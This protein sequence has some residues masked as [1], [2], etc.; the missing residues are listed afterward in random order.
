MTLR[1]LTACPSTCDLIYRVGVAAEITPGFASLLDKQ[2]AISGFLKGQDVFLSP[3]WQWKKYGTRYNCQRSS[4]ALKRSRQVYTF[5][6]V[7]PMEPSFSVYRLVAS[8][9]RAQLHKE[10]RFHCY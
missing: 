6:V 10:Q 8:A 7:S 5:V 2:E 9:G 1:L 4:I 3:Y